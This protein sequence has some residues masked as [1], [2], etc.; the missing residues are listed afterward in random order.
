MYN[1]PETPLMKRLKSVETFEES[2]RPKESSKIIELYEKENANLQ[3]QNKFLLKEIQ[4]H[5]QK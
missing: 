5:K 2:T 3:K 4:K 1:S